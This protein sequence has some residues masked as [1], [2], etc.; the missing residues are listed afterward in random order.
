MSPEQVTTPQNIDA[1]TDVWSLGVVLHRLLTGTLPFDGKSI[2]EV[3]SHVLSAAPLSL[4]DAR[5]D[6]NFDAELDA[7]VARCLEKK[8]GDRFSSMNELAAALSDYLE[9]RQSGTLGSLPPAA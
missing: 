4:R 2:I 3:L 7:I 9:R 5:P 1:R 6:L 8:P